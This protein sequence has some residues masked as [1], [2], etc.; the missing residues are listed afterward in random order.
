[1]QNNRCPAENIVSDFSFSHLWSNLLCGKLTFTKRFTPFTK[2][3]SQGAC[4]YGVICV[5]QYQLLFTCVVWSKL[6]G[7][8]QIERASDME[9]VVPQLPLSMQ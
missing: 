2:D 5:S 7:Q 1:M 9:S 6:L 3:W 4:I 8:K